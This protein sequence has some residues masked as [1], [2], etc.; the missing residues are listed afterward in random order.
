L[1][2]KE[3]HIEFVER[4]GLYNGFL[5]QTAS[6]FDDIVR[7]QKDYSEK[8]NLPD[9]TRPILG[10]KF[11]YRNPITI[12]YEFAYIH[13]IDEKNLE[14]SL[15][16]LK[17]HYFNFVVAQCYEAFETFLKDVVAAS[18]ISMERILFKLDASIDRSNFGKCR[19]TLSKYCNSKNKYNKK[20]FE[21]L[22]SIEPKIS[23]TESDNLLQFEFKEW[24]VVFTE[25]R[26]SIVHSN[27]QFKLCR[28]NNWTKFQN[29]ILNQL[30]TSKTENNIC[31]ISTVT[32]YDYIIRIIAQHGQIIKD[33][34]TN[35]KKN[36]S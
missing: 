20:L 16:N 34:L 5:F 19:E 12:K 26:H 1:T 14:D 24:N 22:Y 3:A 29:D 30:F 9:F 28:S 35:E 7:G 17:I 6:H 13:S 18:L 15:S 11:V 25:I 31:F 10:S 21:I 33:C 2:I 27:G 23:E 36:G 4:V 32:D 8:I